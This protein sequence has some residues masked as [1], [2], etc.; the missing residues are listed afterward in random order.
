MPDSPAQPTTPALEVKAEPAAADRKPWHAPTL[1]QVALQ[2]TGLLSGEG[3]DQNQ[4]STT[5]V[6]AG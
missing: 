3:L 2:I 4:S 5:D 6:Q 1:T